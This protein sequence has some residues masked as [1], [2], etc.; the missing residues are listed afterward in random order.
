MIAEDLSDWTPDFFLENESACEQ[1]LG[2]VDLRASIPSLNSLPLH[3][4]KNQQLVRFRGMIQDMYNPEFYC[5]TFK[6][7][8][9]ITNDTQTRRGKYKDSVNITGD[10]VIVDS[11]GMVNAE[12][13]TYFVI[14]VPCLNSWAE[15]KFPVSSEAPQKSYNTSVK[16]AL[17]SEPMDL[18]ES[19][20]K[21]VTHKIPTKNGSDSSLLS[22]EYVMNFPVP[23]ENGKACLVKIYNEM[24][25]K[26]NQIVDIVG[27]ISLDPTLSMT[28][29]SHALMEDIEFQFHNPPTS[30]IPRLHAI[31]VKIVSR[32]EVTG[33]TYTA[34]ALKN[35][36]ADLRSVLSQILF[37]DTLAADYVICHLISSVYLRRD[38]LPLGTFPLNITNFTLE[39]C[40]SFPEDFYA[41]LALLLPKS[42]LLGITL[43]DLNNLNLSPKK[44]YDCNRLSSGILQLTDNTQLVLD[45]TKLTSGQVSQ[46]GRKN[47]DTFSTL[48]NQQ[49][50]T[51]DFKY[52]TLDFQT[53]IPV[54]ILSETK[55]MIPCDR[56]IVLEKSSENENLYAEILKATMQYLKDESRVTNIRN[57]L[58]IARHRDIEI[59]DSV[60]DVIQKDFVNMRQT[61]KSTSPE[62]LH[63][64]M[65]L[66]RLMSLS[67]G[68][69]RLSVAHWN[70]AVQMEKQRKSRLR[71]RSK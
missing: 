31:D 67:L 33:L 13:Q 39:K 16:R 24:P 3:A 22:K 56:Q 51:Y 38:Q 45:E 41:I 54:L 27:F 43:D 28:E 65:V 10:A 49:K 1:V 2:E 47:Y 42:H 37:G 70:Q 12:R 8:S 64:L 15:E 40:G 21:K 59:E 60:G 71:S 30:L 17:D 32:E 69:E 35:A 9:T 5:D 11:E 57:Y 66:A 58:K 26:L 48:I 7:R 23:N 44:D 53:D 68:S 34:T 19:S 52:Y 55:S 20:N 14:S 25:F 50:V 46:N 63:S 36:R 61:D 6:V 18:E 62:D 29:D 4:F